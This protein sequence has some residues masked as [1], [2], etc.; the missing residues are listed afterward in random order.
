[1]NLNFTGLH[2]T[3]MNFTL[4]D[5]GARRVEGERRRTSQ[6][7]A[8]RGT[9]SALPFLYFLTFSLRVLLDYRRSIAVKMRIV[10]RRRNWEGESEREANLQLLTTFPRF[11]LQPHQDLHKLMYG[12]ECRWMLFPIDDRLLIIIFSLWE[13][14]SLP[15]FRLPVLLRNVQGFVSHFTFPFHSLFIVW[16]LGVTFDSWSIRPTD[17]D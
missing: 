5:S 14:H 1:M 9:V 2:W 6:E 8:K 3:P 17:L 16:L 13:F 10:G 7:R 15:S 12:A 11:A 4:A